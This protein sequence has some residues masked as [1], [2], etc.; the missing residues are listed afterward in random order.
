[1]NSR[2]RIT[3]LVWALSVAICGSIVAVAA[4][5]TWYVNSSTVTGSFVYDADATKTIS[6][7]LKGAGYNYSLPGSVYVRP[8]DPTNNVVAQTDLSFPTGFYPKLAQVQLATN[9]ILT[10]A[11]GTYSLLPAAPNAQGSYICIDDSAGHCASVI[12][13]TGTV[14][15]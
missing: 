9:G 10:D 14:T 12:P 2:L 8:A 6:A 3:S 5:I 13:I 11:G 7:S 15:T 1:M 4:P